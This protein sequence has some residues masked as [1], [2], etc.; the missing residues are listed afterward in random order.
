MLAA[1]LNFNI[2]PQ[3]EQLRSSRGATPR[4]SDNIDNIVKDC[5]KV[6]RAG[7]DSLMGGVCTDGGSPRL[8]LVSGGRSMGNQ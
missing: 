5:A 1:R 3:G 7:G 4:P 8:G 6:L 2:L